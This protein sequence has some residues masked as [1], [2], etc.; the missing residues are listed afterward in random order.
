MVRDWQ[1]RLD[2]GGSGARTPYR[3]RVRAL[4]CL[5]DIALLAKDA[6]LRWVEDECYRLAPALSY[7]ALF[8]LFPLLLLCLTGVGFLLGD[9]DTVRQRLLASVAGLSSAASRAVFDETLRSMQEHRTARGIGAVVGVVMLFLTSSG[10]FSELDASLN[11][12]WRVKAP[13]SKG[14]WATIARAL[15]AKVFSFVVV[16]AAASALLASLVLSTAI[17]AIAQKVNGSSGVP[18]LWHLVDTATSVGCLTLLLSAVYRIVPRAAVQWR[19]VFGA[20][21]L[22]SFLLAGL[23]WTLAWYFAHLS[24]YAAYGA[25]GGVLGLLTWIYVAS[26]LLFYGAEWSRAYAERFG[27]LS[28]EATPPPPSVTSGS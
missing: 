11:L 19:D 18:A 8:S 7:Y 3:G 5:V 26:L 14:I 6:G 2:V 16:V 20:A 17:V 10:A 23:K 25:V 24:S 21:L 4:R 13:P 27:S 9:D 28:R 12:I 1:S 15:T 22:T